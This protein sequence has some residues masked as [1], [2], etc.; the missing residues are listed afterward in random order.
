[1]S[2]NSLTCFRGMSFGSVRTTGLLFVVSCVICGAALLVLGKR[3]NHAT[4]TKGGVRDG[5]ASSRKAERGEA[6]KTALEIPLAASKIAISK[7]ERQLT[8]YPGE[9][10]VRLYRVGLGFNPVGDKRKEGDGRTP[11]GTYYICN[12]NPKSRFCLS[13][14]LSYPNEEDAERGLREGLITRN[15]YDRIVSAI[16]SKSIPPWKTPLGGEIFIHGHGSKRDWTRGCIALEDEDIR[17]LYE[18][19]PVGTRVLIRS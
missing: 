9:K 16:R 17:E 6:A 13:L 11:E 3:Q 8:L 12:K 18:V 10:V 14:G 19:A 7:A 5:K 15:D 2:L 1:M 4:P